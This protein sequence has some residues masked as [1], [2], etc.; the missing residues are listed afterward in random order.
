MYL[1]YQENAE[2]EATDMSDHWRV[3]GVPRRVPDSQRYQLHR[4]ILLQ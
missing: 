2:D 4:R 3:P 1:C